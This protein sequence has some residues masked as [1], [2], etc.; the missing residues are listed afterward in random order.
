MTILGQLQSF[1]NVKSLLVLMSG[2]EG[3]QSAQDPLSEE[4]HLWATELV[5]KSWI[6]MEGALHPSLSE[7]S[8][9]VLAP[10]VQNQ[11]VTRPVALKQLRDRQVHPT[12]LLNR[13]KSHRILVEEAGESK[14]S[15]DVRVETT[16]QM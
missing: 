3:R 6:R 13:L 15:G 2:A 4:L 12:A 5:V 16:G 9:G 1:S 10:L 11:I 8:G 7:Q 14:D